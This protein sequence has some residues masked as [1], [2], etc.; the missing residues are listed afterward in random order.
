[1]KT[2]LRN[3]LILIDNLPTYTKKDIDQGNTPEI[4]TK[5]CLCLKEAYF[6]AFK[7]RKYVNFYI[8]IENENILIKF[9]GRYLKYLGP[10][11][12][13][14][15]LLLERVLRKRNLTFNNKPKVY[16]KSTP[17]IFFKKGN[18]SEFLD[19]FPNIVIVNC[20]KPEELNEIESLNNISEILINENYLFVFLLNLNKES[21]WSILLEH[22]LSKRIYFL[23]MSY[24]KKRKSSCS[25]RILYVNYYFDSNEI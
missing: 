23:E 7:I 18:L 20:E 11:E 5:L 2:N 16:S 9:E 4:I 8:F 21:I 10:D 3:F 19:E 24:L 1:M 22:N 13:S 12:R 6:L 25:E 17:G 14:Q 15:S